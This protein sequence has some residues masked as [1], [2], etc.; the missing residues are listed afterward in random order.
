M[1]KHFVGVFEDGVVFD[2][3]KEYRLVEGQY[4]VRESFIDRYDPG[5]II[6]GDKD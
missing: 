2:F 1:V 3:R 6:R 5:K 4:Q